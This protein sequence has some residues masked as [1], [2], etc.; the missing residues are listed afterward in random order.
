M[1][2]MGIKGRAIKQEEPWGKVF[3]SSSGLCILRAKQLWPKL[4]VFRQQWRAVRGQVYTSFVSTTALWKPGRR[5]TSPSSEIAPLGTSG[6]QTAGLLFSVCLRGSFCSC[7]SVE[8]S[9][10]SGSGCT[11]DAD[12][13]TEQLGA[14]P[15]LALDKRRVRLAVWAPGGRLPIA[16]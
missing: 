1:R 7:R 11:L 2:P 5:R 14:R 4:I 6:W 16:A 12:Y 13:M 9:S 3:A 10:E 15:P 8:G